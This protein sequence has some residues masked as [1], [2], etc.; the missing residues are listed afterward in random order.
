MGCVGG[1]SASAAV[2][3]DCDKQKIIVIVVDERI[4]CSEEEITMSNCSSRKYTVKYMP[5]ENKHKAHTTTK[6]II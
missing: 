4:K 6:E 5:A 3:A 2:V 1:N